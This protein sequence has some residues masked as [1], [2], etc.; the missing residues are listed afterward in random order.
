[1]L[2]P[3]FRPK[4]CIRLCECL[5][6]GHMALAAGYVWLHTVP[7]VVLYLD[8]GQSIFLVCS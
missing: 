3:R 1:M 8:L 2:N 7:I 4:G 5:H 6:C